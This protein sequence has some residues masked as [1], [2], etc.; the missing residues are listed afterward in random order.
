MGYMEKLAAMGML[1]GQPAPEPAAAFEKPEAAEV[2]ATLTPPTVDKPPEA[3][4]AITL[5]AGSSAAGPGD[6]EE[7]ARRRAHEAAEA[8]RKAEWEARRQAKRT[9]AQ[10]EL[11]RIAAMSEEEIIAASV[12]RVGADT[13]KLTRRNMKEAVCEHIQDLC[14][15]DQAFARKA[16]QPGKSMI[17]CFQ[18]INRQARKYAEQEMKDSGMERTGVYGLDV[19]D[20]LCFQWAVDY[21]N[22]PDAQEDHEG[23]EKFVPRP[24]VGKSGSKPAKPKVKK[25]TPQPKAAPRV[26]TGVDGQLSLLEAA[27]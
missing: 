15:R 9:A 5:D 13:E 6:P 25:E 7:A 26:Q 1:P 12:G 4:P 20:G 8:K 17:H 16:M 18:Y 19:P 27:G 21:F 23:E 22:D 24:Y 10:A 11:T 2:P 3:A 14:R